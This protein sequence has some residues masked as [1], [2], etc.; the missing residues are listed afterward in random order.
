V[1][2]DYCSTG[3][4]R[5]IDQ[6]FAQFAPVPNT[7]LAAAVVAVAVFLYKHKALIGFDTRSPL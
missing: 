4:S 2:S 7:R 3:G 5:R 6:V 1:F